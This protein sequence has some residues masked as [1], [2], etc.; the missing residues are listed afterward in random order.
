[1]SL[2][3]LTWLPDRAAFEAR[4]GQAVAASRAARRGLAL[5]LIDLD[6]IEQV[7][8]TLG[9]DIGDRVLHQSAARMA[10]ALGPVAALARLGS[11]DFAACME[12]GNLA[13]AAQ[14]ARAVVSR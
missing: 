1:M 10:R 2:D 8:L 14:R 4:L 7:N 11:D 6:R 12:V 9:R 13:D 3:P 5:L